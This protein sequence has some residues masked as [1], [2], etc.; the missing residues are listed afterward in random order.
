MAKRFGKRR[1]GPW[2]RPATG[3]PGEH[4]VVRARLE[5]LE[6]RADRRA[7][8]AAGD[9]G[10]AAGK[11]GPDR[12]PDSGKVVARREAQFLSIF[13]NNIESP[14]KLRDFHKLTLYI[15]AVL[16]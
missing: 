7:G 13:M 9:L 11:H 10:P 3:G 15:V 5:L 14:S 2:M 12:S 8:A 1:K 4:L 16:R 6:G